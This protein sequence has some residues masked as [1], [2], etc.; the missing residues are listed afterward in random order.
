[1]KNS[2]IVTWIGICVA[3]ATMLFIGSGLVQESATIFT[4]VKQTGTIS[5]KITDDST[6]YINLNAYKVTASAPTSSIS[7]DTLANGASMM[8]A[9]I[10]PLPGNVP[11]P[12]SVPRMGI[13][14]QPVRVVI[15]ND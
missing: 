14:D 11:S 10:T 3:C 5:V 2:S 8:I 9:K 6:A 12:I 4:T 7:N 1:M 15:I 13:A